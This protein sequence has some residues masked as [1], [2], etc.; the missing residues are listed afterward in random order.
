[1]APISNLAKIALNTA[2][3]APLPP[4]DSMMEIDHKPYTNLKSQRQNLLS[5]LV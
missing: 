4:A 1:M 2:K 5:L 3:K